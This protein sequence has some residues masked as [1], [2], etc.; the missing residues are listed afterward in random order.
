MILQNLSNDVLI[1]QSLKTRVEDRDVAVRPKQVID[2]MAILPDEERLK[3]NNE[4][5]MLEKQGLIKLWKS[6]DDMEGSSAKGE[7]QR[8][9][10]EA[11]K[12]EF[13]ETEKSSKKKD[14][15]IQIASSTS[16]SFLEDI[17]ENEES[18]QD[19]VNAALRRLSKMGVGGGGTID[20]PELQDSGQAPLV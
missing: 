17:I 7:E 19:E 13:K 4:L 10:V 16:L 9:Q 20:A 11:G 6:L 5:K 18:D 8:K 12:R 1:L 3:R 2:L 15:L 14:M